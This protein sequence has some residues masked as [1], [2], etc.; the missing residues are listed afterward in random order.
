MANK[1]TTVVFVSDYC[2]VVVVLTVR[3]LDDTGR[4]ESRISLRSA[5]PQTFGDLIELEMLWQEY[6]E[7]GLSGE[8]SA[9]PKGW[10]VL[11]GSRTAPTARPPKRPH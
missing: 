5:V 4:I 10:R 7:S 3:L 6:L 1:S 11:D 2:P 9:L 8:F